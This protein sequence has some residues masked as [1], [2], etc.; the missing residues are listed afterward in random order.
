[1]LGPGPGAPAPSRLPALGQDEAREAVQ[2]LE[3]LGEVL[4]LVDDETEALL[5]RDRQLDE[6]EGVET[7]RA[8]DPLGERGVRCHVGGTPRIEAK[9]LDDD[10]LQLIQ[11]FLLCHALL[12]SRC[13]VIRRKIRSSEKTHP[14]LPP[15]ALT[16]ALTVTPSLP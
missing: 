5:E 10:R 15:L 6:V 2:G 16:L 12:D 1:M 11:H 9:P 4:A 13:N 3:L 8:L 14:S 7:E